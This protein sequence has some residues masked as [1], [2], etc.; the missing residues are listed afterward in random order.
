MARKN[1]TSK[2]GKKGIAGYLWSPFQHLFAATGESAQ[3]LGSG[4][5]KVVKDVVHTAK[6]VGNSFAKHT[7]QAIRGVTM[8]RKKSRRASRK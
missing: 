8:R 1:R 4:A 2:A 5:G 3:K 7:N 6:G